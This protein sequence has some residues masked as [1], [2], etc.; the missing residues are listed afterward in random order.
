MKKSLKDCRGFG[1]VEVLLGV[2]LLLLI[3]GAAVY[4]VK[5]RNNAKVSNASTGV[6]TKP[7]QSFLEVKEWGVRLAIPKG[8][9][10]DMY[11][12]KRKTNDVIDI[13]LKSIVAVAPA[14]APNHTPLIGAISRDK[15]GTYDALSEVAKGFSVAKPFKT[16]GDYEFA[17]YYP[18]ATCY[19]SNADAAKITE[20][21][22]GRTP[23]GPAEK[24]S[25]IKTLE[26]Y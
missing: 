6:N 10:N 2:V 15:S 21:Y 26:S 4:I 19:D 16:I 25:F 7:A 12:E 13:S 8:Y 14:C 23:I 9:E 5:Q 1:A 20:A 3:V 18:Q 17:F 11:Y 22:N 24:A